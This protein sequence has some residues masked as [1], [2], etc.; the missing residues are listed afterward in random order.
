M[1]W[2]ISSNS[3]LVESLG[4]CVYNIKPSANSD[5]FTSSFLIQVPFVFSCL[6]VLTRTS[7][8]MLN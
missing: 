3:F 1:K 8:I 6:I 4:F 2:Y 7:N 5:S